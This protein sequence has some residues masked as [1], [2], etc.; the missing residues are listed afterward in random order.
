[1][2]QNIGRE[3]DEALAIGKR[4]LTMLNVESKGT[5]YVANAVAVDYT[6]VTYQPLASIS[7]G[8]S[9]ATRDGDSLKFKSW[10]GHVQFTRGG[11]D[12]ICALMLVQEGPTFVVGHPATLF[13]GYGT[14]G[15]PLS[16]PVWDA[17]LGFKILEHRVFAL[18]N[19]DPYKIIKWD[20]NF[21]HDVQYY[22][23]TNTV[24]EGQVTVVFISN[25][26]GAT[27]PTVSFGTTYSWVD[28]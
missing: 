1:M 9:D 12:A 8:S 2:L 21:N 20:H 15:A 18:T 25:I 28:N 5:S 22:N 6:G 14:V 26:T 23:G 7:Q 10:K 4:V 3:A 27:A 16:E 24:Y 19:S 17:R 11:V 13:S